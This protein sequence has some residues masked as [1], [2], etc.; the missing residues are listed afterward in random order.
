MAW[1]TLAEGHQDVGLDEQNP[2]ASAA[3]TPDSRTF[4]TPE[5]SEASS[6]KSRMPESGTS[7]SVRGWGAFPPVYLTQPC[8]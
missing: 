7:G 5:R 1:T 2:E 6:L 4:N 8:L 3:S